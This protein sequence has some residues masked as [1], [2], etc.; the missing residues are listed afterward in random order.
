MMED[1]RKSQQRF[2]QA[3][4]DP[5]LYQSESDDERRRMG[6]YQSLFL[7]NIT[8]FLQSGFPVL[9]AIVNEE[10]WDKVVRCFFVEHRCRSPYFSQIGKEFV[11]YLSSEPRCLAWL[12]AFASELAHYE[13]LE[14]DVS[15]RHDDNSAAEKGN[16]GIVM[17][18]LASLVSYA[19][20][21]HLIGKDYLPESPSPERNYYVVYREQDYSVQFLHINAMTALLLQ[22]IESAPGAIDRQQLVEKLSEAAP[23]IDSKILHK[24]VEDTLNQM[25]NKGIVSL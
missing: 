3:V 14:L 17:S 23:H 13:W 18:S 4:R 7:N 21:V 11:E 9:H 8:N 24:G 12:P 6:I 2:V 5:E 1:F 10:T 15:I 25:A 20:P 16:N 22:S 19:Y